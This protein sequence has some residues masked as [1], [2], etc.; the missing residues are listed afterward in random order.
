[1]PGSVNNKSLKSVFS[2]YMGKPCYPL[3]HN[4]DALPNVRKPCYDL[5]HNQLAFP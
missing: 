5:I 1:M 4:H 3:I 2:D